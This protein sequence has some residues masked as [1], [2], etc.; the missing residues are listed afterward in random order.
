MKKSLSFR[1]LSCIL[2]VLFIA[3]GFVALRSNPVDNLVSLTLFLGLLILIK[4]IF[5]FVNYFQVKKLAG[6]A[7]PFFII[8][9]IL[10]VILG[11]LLLTNSYIGV[12]GLPFMLALWFVFD[13]IEGLIHSRFNR[14]I[15]KGYYWASIILRLLGLAMG[16]L[17]LFDPV[18]AILTLSFM[19]GF[20]M[21]VFGFDQ[22]MNGLI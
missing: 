8:S 6:S 5:D 9:G 17:L 7:S 13:S 10:D 2:G 3:M 1:V 18:I 21:M 4:G 20:Y 22:V 19:V 16:I 11:I 15:S 14:L 12:V